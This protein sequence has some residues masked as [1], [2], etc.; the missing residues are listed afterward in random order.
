MRNVQNQTIP[1]STVSPKLLALYRKSHANVC[2][3]RLCCSCSP[4]SE[5]VGAGCASAPDQNACGGLP[6][7][8]HRGGCLSPTITIATATATRK[9]TLVHSVCL[10]K[11]RGSSTRSA[12]WLSASVSTHCC[13]GTAP[14]TPTVVRV[15]GGR[16]ACVGLLVQQL[17]PFLVYFSAVACISS[18]TEFFFCLPSRR[19]GCFLLS[20]RRGRKYFALV[21]RV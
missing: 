18:E 16:T 14:S 1:T 10:K 2:F 17:V 8:A 3:F 11:R 5:L 6:A 9:P 15:G 19:A 21:T 20:A 12:S 7:P 13:R 4:P